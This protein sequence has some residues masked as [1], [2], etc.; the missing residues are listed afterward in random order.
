MP[1]KLNTWI[2]LRRLQLQPLF[3]AHI[4]AFRRFCDHFKVQLR[5][6][7]DQDKK[8]QLL[9]ELL[10]QHFPRLS[11]LMHLDD[12]V[13]VQ[14]IQE[15]EMMTNCGVQPCHYFE[16]TYPRAFDG[17]EDPPWTFTYLGK[18]TWND[19]IKVGIV[20]SRDVHAGTT[21]IFKTVLS[22]W[23]QQHSCAII[24]GGAYGV[25]TWAHDLALTHRKPTFAWMPSGLQQIYPG[26]FRKK[27]AEI[28]LD[29]AVM[30]EFPFAQTVQKHHFHVRNRLIAAMSDVLIIPQ[31]ARQSGT[32]I[33]AHLALSYGKPLWVFPGHI[34]QKHMSG[35]LDLLMLGASLVT[36]VDDLS[37]LFEA[38]FKIQSELFTTNSVM[39]KITP[40][41]LGILEKQL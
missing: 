33:T 20:G 12:P 14:C 25:D 16:A 35:N 4:A 36:S 29:G 2:Y 11:E 5:A 19:H 31:A 37:M 3:K 13:I 1:M 28:C 32:M 27:V 34:L 40:L 41:H 38:E 8:L 15:F 23:A 26:L 10:S 30:S 7:V 17:I 24:S 6:E 22:P 9:M 21:E 18:P 39:Q